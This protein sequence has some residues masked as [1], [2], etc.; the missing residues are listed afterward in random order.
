M[1]KHNQLVLVAVDGSEQSYNAVHQAIKITDSSKDKIII[2]MVKDIRK[3]YGISNAGSE[4]IPALDRITKSVLIKAARL[5]PKGIEFETKEVIGN[6]KHKIV[7][8]SK[9]KNIDTIVMGATGKDFFDQLL[10][11]S[12]TRYVIDHAWCN[13]LIVK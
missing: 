5:I 8:F 1:E 12:T 9:E 3:Y 2:L 6:S 10:L 4:E 7:D 13:V 11:G